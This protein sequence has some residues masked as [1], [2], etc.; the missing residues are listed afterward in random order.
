[1]AN[2]ALIDNAS[3]YVWGV[4]QAETPSEA[5]RKIDHQNGSDDR[6]YEEVSRFS[7]SNE[8]GYHVHEVPDDFEVEDGQDEAAIRAAS[9]FPCVACVATRQED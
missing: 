7:F 8:S 6:T 4:T 3:G 9:S 5:C 2:Y 1:M